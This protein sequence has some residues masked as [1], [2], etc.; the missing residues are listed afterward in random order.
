MADNLSKKQRSYCMSRVRSRDTALETKV[1]TEL[2]KSGL[3]F[4]KHVKT[5]PGRPDIV[6]PVARLAVF[7]DGDFWHGYRFP[8][9]RHAVPKF[10]RIKINGNRDRDRR[11][12]TKLRRMG[13]R[14][15]RIWQHEV[16][17]DLRSCINRVI[18]EY[19]AAVKGK[20]S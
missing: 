16:E 4:R 7:L 15:L 17:R 5:L 14:V 19:S 11:N 10:W 3:R 6:F 9:W 20:R 8:T 18:S 13:W 12:F 1:R 2:F